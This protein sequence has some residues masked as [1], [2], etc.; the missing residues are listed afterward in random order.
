[1]LK[2]TA[3]S[4]PARLARTRVDGN[5]PDTDASGEI[6]SGRIDD[7]MV[8]LSNSTKKKKSS[9]TGFFTPEASL[10]FT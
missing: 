3:P 2:T 8:N 7:R 6:G 4:V 9:G 5:E 10:A 1:M